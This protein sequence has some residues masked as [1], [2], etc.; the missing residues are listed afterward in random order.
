MMLLLGGAF[1]GVITFVGI[2]LLLGIEEIRS[3][4]VGILR[5]AQRAQ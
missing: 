5:R 3:I 1:I 4:P 2:S